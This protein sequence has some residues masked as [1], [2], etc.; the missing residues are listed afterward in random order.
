MRPKGFKIVFDFYE[1]FSGF[2]YPKFDLP[3]TQIVTKLNKSMCDKT[4]K[5]KL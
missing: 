1:R 3:T 4:Q 5:L 2:P